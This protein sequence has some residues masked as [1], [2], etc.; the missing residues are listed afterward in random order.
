[1]AVYRV[2]WPFKLI[3]IIKKIKKKIIFYFCIQIQYINPYTPYTEH[4]IIIY[5][6]SLIYSTLSRPFTITISIPFNKYKNINSVVKGV[7]CMDCVWRVW[8]SV[9]KFYTGIHS[10]Q[11]PSCCLFNPPCTNSQLINVIRAFLAVLLYLSQ[12]AFT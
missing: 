8:I 1:M 12:Q 3:P 11:F 6:S 4:T 2:F 10:S 5:I 9:R 7:L